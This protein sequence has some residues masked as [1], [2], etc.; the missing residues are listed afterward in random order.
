M[1]CVCAD[2]RSGRV[3]KINERLF[4]PLLGMGS[5]QLRLLSQQ[6]QVCVADAILSLSAIC[7]RDSDPING[8]H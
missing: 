5:G 7:H 3:R 2:L 6:M 1:L 8:I 4:V